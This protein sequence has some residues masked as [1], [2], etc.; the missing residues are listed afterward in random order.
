[1]A[2]RT[3]YVF[4]FILIFLIGVLPILFMIAKSFFVE[5]NFSF[6]YY[7]EIFSSNR[8]WILFKNSFI[9]SFLTAFFTT[10]V[11]VPIGIVLGKTDLPFKNVFTFLFSIPLLIPPYIVAVS[12]F[13]IFG[14]NGFLSKLFGSKIGEITSSFYFGLGG[15]VFVLFSVFLPVV[16]IL[17]MAYLKVINP[18]LEEA[19]KLVSNWRLVLKDITIPLIFSGIFLGSMLVFILSFGELGV[20]LFLRYNVFPVETFTQ[21]SAFYNFGSATASAVPLALIAFLFLLVERIFLH[22]KT[23]QLK[24][25]DS[26]EFL[27][28]NLKSCKKWIFTVIFLFC[29]FIVI[30]PFSVLI[31]KSLSLEAYKQAFSMA[32]DSLF[33]SFLFAFIG[34]TFLTFIG[35]LVGYFVYKNEL[36]FSKTLDSITIFIFALP[37]AVIGVGLISTFNNSLTNFIYTTPAIIIIGYVAKYLAITNRLTVAFLS[38]IPPS[39]EESAQIVGARW[40]RRMIFIVAPLIKKGLIVSWIVSFIFCFRDFG[41]T[42]LVYPPGQDTF[43]VR[44]FTLMANGSPELISAL[45]VVMVFSV[46]FFIIVGIFLLKLLKNL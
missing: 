33:R 13:Y 45:C 15:V 28:I 26:T 38:Q 31:F 3:A 5:G 10:V 46:L 18:R 11:G 41:L 16:I 23:Y 30:F 44:I 29:F 20:P 19:G 1:M 14:K 12:W 17:T 42:M 25:A 9:L 22:E 40:F 4:V 7:Q 6:S 36:P 43:P 32:G 27:V 24:L 8:A 39:M 34:A 21:F 37:S 35:F 2:K